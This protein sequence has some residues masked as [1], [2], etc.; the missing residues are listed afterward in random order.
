MQSW[1][2]L[3]NHGRVLLCIATDPQ[4]RLREIAASIDITERRAHGIV[5]D[6]VEAGYVVKSKVGRRNH[7]YIQAH[8]PLPEPHVADNAIGDIL[9]L[10]V[11]PARP[12]NGSAGAHRPGVGN[13]TPT[14]FSPKPD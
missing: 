2:F 8:L 1:R 7:Y 3:T 14:H 12:R 9:E 13:H 4:A 6:L 5:S 11:G 10:L